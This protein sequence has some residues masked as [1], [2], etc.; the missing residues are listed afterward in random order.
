MSVGVVFVFISLNINFLV[1]HFYYCIDTDG[2]YY[3]PF[4][5]LLTAVLALFSGLII[6]LIYDKKKSVVLSIDDDFG[7]L[8]L[9]SLEMGKFPE[10]VQ[11]T[12]S[13]RKI[14]IGFVTGSLEPNGDTNAYIKLW[15]IYSG[16]RD[17]DNLQLH[18]D[19]DYSE[20]WDN[21]HFDLDY[22]TIVIPKKDIVN[23]NI[24]NWEIYNTLSKEN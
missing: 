1:C 19:N 24:F 11:F 18:I 15:P 8:I 14:Y 21:D 2:L 3:Q 23:I 4:I 6:N 17:K 5:G 7:K 9:Q 13:T 12:L 10:P 16:H 20:F 22:L